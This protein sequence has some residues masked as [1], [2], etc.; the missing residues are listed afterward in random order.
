MPR[1]ARV[2][3]TAGALEEEEDA[4]SV[5]E[6]EAVAAGWMLDFLCLSLC[7]AFRDGRP[8]ILHRTRDSAEGE[9]WARPGRSGNR[10]ARLR[11]GLQ[12]FTSGV[13][14]RAAC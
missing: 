1:T 14:D 5:A 6:A 10:S 12:R 2:P 7:R 9:C 4:G 11:P 8:T 13:G 3:G